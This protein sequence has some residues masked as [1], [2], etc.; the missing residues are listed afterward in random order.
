MKLVTYLLTQIIPGL[1]SN[2]AQAVL[3]MVIL[4]AKAVWVIYIS[5]WIC[6]IQWIIKSH[7]Q[8]RQTAAFRLG[9][10]Q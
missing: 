5:L 3:T 9:F 4:L 10:C 1:S 2:V 8:E 7:L 6:L